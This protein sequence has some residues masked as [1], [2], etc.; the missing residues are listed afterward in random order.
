MPTYRLLIEYDGTDFHGWQVQPNG[1]TVQE[2]LE[3][4]ATTVLRQP[5]S[6]IGSG[7]TDAGVHARGQV[8]HFTTGTPVNVDR[9]RNALNGLLPP[10]IAVLA[11]E[12][13][14]DGFHAR[15]SAR[16]RR[17]HYYTGLHPHPLERAWRHVLRPAPDFERMNRAA[18]ALRGTHDFS[19]FCRTRSETENRRCTVFEAH[20]V[21]EDRPGDWHFRI[22][23]DRFLHGMV[24]AIVGTLL[25]IGRGK[26]PEDDLLRVLASGDRREAGPAAPA[27]GLVLEHVEYACDG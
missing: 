16:R 2:A 25:E 20:W 9:L 23:A 12:E 15:Y 11:L 6:I 21:A 4:A 8:A 5:V 22:T 19:A 26:R 7:R 27:R 1:P 3:R 13:A 24:R 14:P 17:Y 10:S 18:A